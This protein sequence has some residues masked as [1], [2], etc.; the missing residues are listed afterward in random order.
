MFT[1]DQIT[2]ILLSF[3][4][5]SVHRDFVCVIHN[6]RI[7]FAI[8]QLNILFIGRSISLS[9]TNMYVALKHKPHLESWL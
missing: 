5:C 8:C 2:C 9:Y 1:T 3:D 6:T 4:S 7:N